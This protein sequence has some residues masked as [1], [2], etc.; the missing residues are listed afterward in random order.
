MDDE[1]IRQ[2]E[3]IKAELRDIGDVMGE[4]RDLLATLSVDVGG[5]REAAGLDDAHPQIVD[6][7]RTIVRSMGGDGDAG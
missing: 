1:I 7:L 2:L 3:S 6:A 4:C 5:W